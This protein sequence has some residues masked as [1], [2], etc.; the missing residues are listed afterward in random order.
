MLSRLHAMPRWAVPLA[1]VVL[2]FIGLSAGPVLGG[3]CLLAIAF[4]LSWLAYLAWPQL[5]RQG[6]V[7]RMVVLVPLTAI[8]VARLLGL[9]G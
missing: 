8:G 4:F 9:W 1:T 6:R 7:L 2:V 5:P 3:L